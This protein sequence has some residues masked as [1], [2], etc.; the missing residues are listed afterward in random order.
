LK[1]ERLTAR[2]RKRLKKRIKEKNQHLKA[3]I[4]KAI[5]QKVD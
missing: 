5:E 1:I 2:Q 3:I 4:S